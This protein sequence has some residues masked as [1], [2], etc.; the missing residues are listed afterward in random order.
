M[1]FSIKSF[2]ET[3]LYQ[4]N[5][6]L[7]QMAS[8]IQVRDKQFIIRIA[9]QS[10]TIDRLFV[11]K[12]WMTRWLLENF[13]IKL[14]NTTFHQTRGLVQV[15]SKNTFESSI[16][17]SRFLDL[18]KVK[19]IVRWC[20]FSV[21]RKLI[22]WHISKKGLITR[23]ISRYANW[24]IEQLFIHQKILQKRLKYLKSIGKGPSSDTLKY[25]CKNIAYKLKWWS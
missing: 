12:Y 24:S 21:V 4:N 3:N 11:M 10:L 8:N 17:F 22:I 1:G 13:V 23:I 19:F 18:L 9:D 2:K 14:L 15:K 7:V 16:I 5:Y 25:C 6:G 20:I